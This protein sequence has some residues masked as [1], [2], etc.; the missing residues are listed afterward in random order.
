MKTMSDNSDDR[1]H[2]RRFLARVSAVGA[3]ALL[4]LPRLGRGVAEPPPETRRI[5]L[6]QLPA[7]CVATQYVAEELLRLG[8]FTDIEY[9]ELTDTKTPGA[10]NRLSAP[11][12]PL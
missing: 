7:I 4:G 2:R 9:V 5:R 10:Y 1:F 8:G 11:L 12:F 6:V 3:A